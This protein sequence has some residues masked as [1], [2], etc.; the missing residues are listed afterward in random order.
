MENLFALLNNSHTFS[1][2]YIEKLDATIYRDSLGVV[3]AGPSPDPILSPYP[4]LPC[5][6]KVSLGQHPRRFGHVFERENGN[7]NRQKSAAT[8]PLIVDNEITLIC[9]GFIYNYRELYQHCGIYRE[10]TTDM[11]SQKIQSRRIIIH[12][13][14]RYGI[15][16]TLH[17]LDGVFAFILLDNTLKT[18]SKLYVARDMYGDRPLYSFAPKSSTCSSLSSPHLFRDRE[19]ILYGFASEKKIWTEIYE[20]LRFHDYSEWGTGSGMGESGQ[21]SSSDSAEWNQ[22]W[23]ILPFPPG[24]YSAFELEFKA[25]SNW[26]IVMNRHPFHTSPIFSMMHENNWNLLWI[27]EMHKNMEKQMMRTIDK[28]VTSTSTYLEVDKM[29]K[30][31]NPEATVTFRPPLCLLTNQRESIF[32]TEILGKYFSNQKY[33]PLHTVSISIGN[34]VKNSN[35]S[36]PTHTE[37]HRT[38]SDIE[39]V[40]PLVK[41]ILDIEESQEN[42]SAIWREGCISFLLAE[43]ARENGLEEKHSSIWMDTGSR[44]LFGMGLSWTPDE[45]ED[46]LMFDKKCRD[47]FAKVSL[48]NG[49][50][51]KKCFRAFGWDVYTPYLDREFIQYYLSSPCSMRYFLS[52]SEDT[53]KQMKWLYSYNDNRRKGQNK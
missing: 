27:E 6:I 35:T 30:E 26:K 24:C 50:Y 48:Y 41:K 13:Y 53:T 49:L 19:E 29:E 18:N 45:N 40:M 14:R 4:I 15:E 33:P 17:L 23:E 43:Y 5:G 3:E 36:S 46:M 28:I 32:L 22:K 42:A 9:D 52:L 8:S 51:T 16:H 31:Y 25:I 1:S 20:T 37:I 44:E 34:Y 21:V 2:D 39:R 12:L 10:P 11:D 38:E 7:R 47:A